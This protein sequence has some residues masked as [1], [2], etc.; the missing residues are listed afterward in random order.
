MSRRRAQARAFTALDELLADPVNPL[1]VAR[2]EP[3]LRVVRA[4]L[5]A[6]LDRPT[7]AAWQDVG[8]ALRVLAMGVELGIFTDPSHE[9]GRALDM[10]ID[11]GEHQGRGL[12]ADDWHVLRGVL[13]DYAELLATMPARALIRDQRFAERRARA[14]GEAVEGD[15]TYTSRLRAACARLGAVER[16]SP[17]VSP[18]K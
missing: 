4:G 13:E 15:G 7:I 16:A 9:C 14:A 17:I 10:L 1:P 11:L 6:L 12:D 5:D 3:H 18:D 8:D 2:I